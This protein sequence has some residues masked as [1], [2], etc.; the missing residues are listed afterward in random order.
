MDIQMIKAHGKGLKCTKNHALKH[1]CLCI[2]NLGEKVFEASMVS[3]N[4]ICFIVCPFRAYLQ[5]RVTVL[6]LAKQT[7]CFAPGCKFNVES[8]DVLLP[9]RPMAE[10]SSHPLCG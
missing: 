7:G 1:S 10:N 6:I 4:G 3:D 8:T 2:I 5:F 9:F